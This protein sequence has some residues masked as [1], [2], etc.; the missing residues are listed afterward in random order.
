MRKTL[1]AGA[2]VFLTFGSL[3][4][5]YLTNTG[6]F[7]FK[8]PYVEIVSRDLIASHRPVVFV[9]VNVIPMDGE[10]IL[11]NQTVV[12][13][14]GLIKTIGDHRTVEAPADALLIEAQGKY[15]MPGLVDMHVHMKELNELLLFVANGVTAVRDMWGTTGMQL[16]MGF[17][18]QKDLRTRIIQGELLG[19]TIYS[20]GPIMEGD[21]P[22]MP[23]MPV[24][25]TPEEAGASIAWQ[26]TQG[27]DYVK[28]YDNLMPD[29]YK[30]I[31]QAARDQDLPV[32]GH[33]PWRV[34]LDAVLAGG[35]LTI[36]HLSGYIDPDS[37]SFIIPEE[38]LDYYA[39]LTRQAGVW[40]TPTIVLYQKIGPGSDAQRLERQPGMEYVSPRMRAI[41]R[42]YAAQM[43]KSLTYEG[44]DYPGRI[45]EIY[46]RMTRALLE[47]GAGILLG[48]DTDNPYLVPGF[49]LHEELGL[50][51]EAGLSPYQAL[52]A[53]TR[54]AA[55]ALGKLD[56]F[57]TIETGKWA[58][59]ILLEA[60]PLE[61]VSNANRRVGVMLRGRWLMDSE[62]QEMLTGL[63]V[64]FTPSTFDR[65]WPG[66]FLLLGLIVGSGG[67]PMRNRW[68]VYIVLG[69]L[70]GIFD[71]YFLQL[72]SSIGQF[73]ALNKFI[74]QAPYIVI[75]MVQLL[76]ITLNFGIW[77]VPVIPVSIFEI[78]R[79]G[80]V[81]RAALAAAMVWVCAIISYYGYYA[82]L[83]MFAGLPNLNF[84]LYENRHSPTFWAEWWPP[85]YRIIVVQFVE[86][87]GVAIIGGA[88]VGALSAF[89]YRRIH[90]LFGLSTGEKA[91]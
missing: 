74:G 73:D 83:I 21:P 44:K 2:G 26:K 41:W 40:N 79:S 56:E 88:I 75:L 91:F 85:F 13:Q 34:G 46:K 48:T 64:S 60:N 90:R 27:Y 24:I 42:L 23:L 78:R 32:I 14:D 63:R 54:N 62:L 80:S 43:S 22:S 81:R 19:P 82:F 3:I 59:L 12:V 89:T 70:F 86:W 51:V 1:S 16:W 5:L 87:I 84:M 6:M 4:L 76:L 52:E 17:P 37:A 47:N 50:L 66:G 31:L 68:V 77:L 65:L 53:G 57:G 7:S 61:D 35:Q 28:V 36:E 25:R 39:A 9:S 67:S 49:S 55:L 10:R 38:Q 69:L 15:L 30:A 72:L 8:I 20:S 11:E 45:D 18:D 29:T 33:V 71:W 58:D